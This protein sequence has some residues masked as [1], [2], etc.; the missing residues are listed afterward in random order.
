MQNG[1]R[2]L[3]WTVATGSVAGGAAWS[4]GTITGNA[5]VTICPTRLLIEVI[6]G[7]TQ[8]SIS[9]IKFGNEEQMVG[10]PFH[11]GI[12]DSTAMQPVPFVM[13]CLKAGMPYTITGTNLD[14]DTAQTFY[15]TFIGPAVG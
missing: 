8:G 1:C 10:G 5:T 7:D 11:T 4:G 2:E 12:F 13:S 14:P 3:A 9:S 15:I 6:G